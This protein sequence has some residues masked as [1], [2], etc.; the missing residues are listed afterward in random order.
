MTSNGKKSVNAE[1]DEMELRALLKHAVP[2][3]T[4]EGHRD[5]WPRML[6]RLGERARRVPWFDWALAALVA[7]C[8]LFF[9]G[10]IPM[11]LYHL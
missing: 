9:P 6:E 10:V 1:R 11:L 3:V 2:P 8:V 7:A 4:D 5:L